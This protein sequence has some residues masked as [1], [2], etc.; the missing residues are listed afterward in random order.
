MTPKPPLP[1]DSSPPHDS[2]LLR[3][4]AA[5]RAEGMSWAGIGAALDVDPH[6]IELLAG[7]D[8]RF[9]ANV[10]TSHK[11]VMTDGFTEAACVFRVQLRSKSEKIA[12]GAAPGS[13]ATGWTATATAPASP[14][15]PH[16]RYPHSGTTT[17]TRSRTTKYSTWPRTR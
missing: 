1:P 10:R 2:P 13:S 11:N 17:P 8:P 16:Q 5:L 6:E 14:N 3:R 4:T 15:P 12:A 7:D 9:Y